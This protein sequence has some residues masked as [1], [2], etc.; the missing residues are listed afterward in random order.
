M[1]GLANPYV[2]AKDFLA[3]CEFELEGLIPDCAPPALGNWAG[4]PDGSLRNHGVEYVSRHARDR[5]TLISD[6]EQLLK[7]MKEKYF[8]KKSDH[9]SERTSTHVHIN[10]SSLTDEQVRTIVLLYALFEEF[11]FYMVKPERRHNIHCV[12]LT[13]THLPHH[14]KENRESLRQRWHKNTALNMG[15]L[16]DLGTLEFRHLHGT[17]SMKELDEW[18]HVLENLWKLGQRVTI[19]KENIVNKD[20]VKTWFESI[21]F[22]CDKIMGMSP[23]LNTI[24]KNS[25]IDVKLSLS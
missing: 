17:D 3:S 21:F 9:F 23:N 13:E 16:T 5:K 6:A 7:E 10:C 18:L 12:P 24:I 11:F 1:Y 20:T 4:K 19:T 8:D 14:N 25:L 2:K 22:P 15:R